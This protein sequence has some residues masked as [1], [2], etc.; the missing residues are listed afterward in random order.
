MNFRCAD[1]KLPGYFVIMKENVTESTMGKKVIFFDVGYTLVCE[2]AVWATRCREQA[3]GAEARAL[4]LTAE[5]IYQ[6][7]AAATIAHLPQYRTVVSKFGFTVPAPY[8]HEL[9]TLYPDALE[10]LAALARRYRLGIIANQTDGLRQRLAAFGI[11]SY[12]EPCAIISSWDWQ[13]IKP[14][15]QLF[16]IACAQAGCTPEDAVMIGDRLD[17]DI[18]PAKAMGMK[19]IWIRQG[20]GGMQSPHSP[21]E[22]PD[23]AVDGL[24]ELLGLF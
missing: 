22:E 12:F 5:D 21:N 14:D 4:G 16:T 20:F 2:D 17:N 19:T 3:E 1:L 18:A 7:I 9:E 10:V 6:E 23:T 13:I 11:L 8:R 15:L 24:T